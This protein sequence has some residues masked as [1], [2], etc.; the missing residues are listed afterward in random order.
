MRC[1]RVPPLVVV[2][3]VVAVVLVS[4]SACYEHTILSENGRIVAVS[5]A[6][7]IPRRRHILLLMAFLSFHHA[8]AY[9]KWMNR[10]K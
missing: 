3:V 1:R 10:L 4:V 6:Q 2:V 8:S 9:G 7:T 5:G